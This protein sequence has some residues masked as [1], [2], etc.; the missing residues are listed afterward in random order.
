MAALGLEERMEVLEQQRQRLLSA[1]S[2]IRE[3]ALDRDVENALRGLE[4]AVGALYRSL[5]RTAEGGA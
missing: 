1:I 5:G 2:A 4:K 3:H